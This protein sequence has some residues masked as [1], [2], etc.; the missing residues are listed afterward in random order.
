M[1]RYQIFN[2]CIYKIKMKFKK[3]K[4][5]K[6]GGAIGLLIG[7]TLG[8]ILFVI[9]LI[10]SQKYVISD[11]FFGY[12]L[13]IFIFITL[14]FTLI[15]T[16]IGFLTSMKNKF[17]KIFGIIGSIFGIFITIISF[18][19]LLYNFTYFIIPIIN[20]LK[21]ISGCHYECY[22]I[23]FILL[24]VNFIIFTLIGLLIGVVISKI[25]G[26]K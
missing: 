12:F 21:L 3:L 6:K 7:L 19:K 15:G 10:N 25:R 2:N 14:P 20:L 8:S 16:F 23:Y 5:W 4:G 24:P 18:T 9:S 26:N 13:P 17:V 1:I 22:G 11:P